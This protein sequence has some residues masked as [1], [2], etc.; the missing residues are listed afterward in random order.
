MSVFGR[1]VLGLGLR[2][3]FFVL[4]LGLE[5]CVLDSTSGSYSYG[6]INVQKVIE[7]ALKL[8]FFPTKSRKS[9]KGLGL[10]PQTPSVRRL[11]CISLFS[12]RPT[13]F[14][15]KNLF[16]VQA[17]FLL[18]KCWLRLWSHSMLPTSFSSDYMDR[19]Q[20]AAGLMCL[21]F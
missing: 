16:L 3:F 9:P 15:E 19:I 12:T 5:P 14:L 21:F 20:N 7:M 10:C 11:S 13:I 2:F 8:L 1:S 17:P 4:G 18:A 6:F